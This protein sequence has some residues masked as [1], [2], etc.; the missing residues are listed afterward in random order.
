MTTRLLSAADAATR[1]GIKRATLYAYVSRGFLTAFTRPD[2]RGSWFDPLQL[3]A[4]VSRARVPAERRPDVRIKS[5][6]TLIERGR[7]W[8]RG[9]DPAAL[10]ERATFEQVAEWLW[11]GAEPARPVRWTTD[12]RAVGDARRA[13][14]RLRSAASATDRLRIIVVMLASAD[15]LR[16]DL[17]PAGVLATARRLIANAV[18]ALALSPGGGIAAQL[19][20]ALSPRPMGRRALT[21]VDRT[22]GV[23]ADH[24][25]APSTVAVRVAASFGADPYAAVVAGLGAIAGRRH[26]GASHRLEEL[27]QTASRTRPLEALVGRLLEREGTLPGFGH[28]LYPDGDPRVPIILRLA[29]TIGPTDIADA[30]FA[31]AHRQELPPPNVDAA[32]A[33][34]TRVLK[35]PPGS[36]ELIFATARLAGWLAHAMEE[37]ADRTDFRL[38]SVYTGPRPA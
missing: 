15:P 24:E 26:G 38:R 1:L 11:T 10:V 7:Y 33:A 36:G 12:A 4:V 32:L 28:P 8:Y 29:R 18:G 3:D 37:Y 27:L 17:R 19:A 2:R 6:V 14:A 35:L 34:L 5:A 21:A 20:S 31:V 13:V 9:V 16:G 22:L 23:M 30:L 25:L